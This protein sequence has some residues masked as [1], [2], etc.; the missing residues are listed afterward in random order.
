MLYG[1]LDIYLEGFFWLIFKH[2]VYNFAEM[3]SFIQYDCPASISYG[4]RHL[5]TP[6]H[7]TAD[8]NGPGHP[9]GFSI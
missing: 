8:V 6:Q 3:P 1:I 2:Y 7:L 9:C 5:H 4:P